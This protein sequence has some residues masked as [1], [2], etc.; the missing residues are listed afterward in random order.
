MDFTLNDE[1][2][3]VRDL[4]ERIL[5]DK[6]DTT[7][8]REIESSGSWF[9]ADT[10][11]ELAKAGLLGIALPESDGGGG[12]GLVEACLV[13]E[14]VGRRV[15]PVPYLD[16][17]IGAALT[18]AEHGTTEQRGRLLPPVIDGSALLAVG[19]HEPDLPTIPELPS[20]AATRDGHGWR[21]DGTKSAVAHAESAAALVVPARTGDPGVGVF[22]VDPTSSAVTLQ[23]EVAVTGEPQWT[24]QLDGCRVDGDAV[25]GDP[26]AG[27]EVQRWLLDRLVVGACATQLGV[28]EEALAITAGY[29]SERE[30]FGTKLGT[31]QAVAQRAANAYIDTEAIRLTSLQAAWRL[32]EGLRAADELLIAK[33]W[34]AEGGQR[35]VHAA[36]H[37][38]GGVGV[39]IDYPVH[40]YFRW[41]KVLELYLGGATP[42]LAQLGR[43]LA[44]A[45]TGVC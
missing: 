43:N 28:C 17:I 5:G 20:A 41:A 31:F 35:V 11:S 38:H 6:V 9:D 44:A 32:A 12:L 37:L 4:A 8:L 10:W 16:C 19:V 3:A 2:Q 39:D 22:L 21:I 26:L 33:F 45:P 24:V 23:R 18:V 30:Q 42:S 1:Q 27:S 15:A 13:A 29:V 34:A 40:R 36:Q 14:Q 25:L 7:R